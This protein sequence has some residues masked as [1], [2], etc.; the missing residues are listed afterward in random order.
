LEEEGEKQRKKFKDPQIG[1]GGRKG[2]GKDPAGQDKV[3]Q[4]AV[5]NLHHRRANGT[6]AKTAKY[7][8]MSTV[9]AVWGKKTVGV[10]GTQL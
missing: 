10:I 7:K 8:G 3:S 1:G 4:A 2:E 9:G 6:D 5:E